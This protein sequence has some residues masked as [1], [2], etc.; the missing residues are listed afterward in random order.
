M[1]KHILLV[2]CF[3]TISCALI[4]Q[5]P[6]KITMLDK[7][8]DE[9]D[10]RICG[11]FGNR[12]DGICFI[13]SDK[14][15]QSFYVK[16]LGADNKFKT[17]QT[18]PSELKDVWLNAFEL[19]G[20]NSNLIDLLDKQGFSDQGFFR[21]GNKYYLLTI[22][23]K[24]LVFMV[25]EVD[26][27]QGK[28]KFPGKNIGSIEKEFRWTPKEVIISPN[29]EKMWVFQNNPESKK[30]V[31]KVVISCSAGFNQVKRAVVDFGYEQKQ[32]KFMGG[33]A[34]D[35]NLYCLY[36]L[37][38][39][40]QV[41][42]AKLNGVKPEVVATFSTDQ[43]QFTSADVKS[44]GVGKF[45]IGGYYSQVKK[46]V[47]GWFTVQV[48]NGV[49]SDTYYYTF[50]KELVSRYDEE[51][52][53]KS[54][55]LLVKDLLHDAS[56]GQVT[57]IGQ[58]EV[59]QATDGFAF[60]FPNIF[61]K[62][63]N[64]YAAGDAYYT[65]YRSI[66]VS[67]SNVAGGVTFSNKIPV[68]RFSNVVFMRIFSHF[69]VK[70]KNYFLFNEKDS[71]KNSLAEINKSPDQLRTIEG[72]VGVMVEADEKGNLKKYESGL[73][74]GKAELFRGKW[75]NIDQNEFLGYTKN[76]DIAL[77]KFE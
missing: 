22:S 55:A 61:S 46:E 65:T 33:T 13:A 19:G 4:G 10:D 16:K 20:G 43:I 77:I 57:V 54:H 6:F 47:S 63:Q 64:W 26:L 2:C 27:K 31:S 11:M 73:T 1:R 52:N 29:H 76:G 8:T 36:E 59:G 9:K 50:P 18:L 25:Y 71:N 5:N 49:K 21:L 15:K 34:D 72:G 60:A 44:I 30:T 38:D 51:K 74:N 14:K 32:V 70:G 62:Y 45:V 48:N 53:F 40:N 7:V 39:K 28:I 75:A 24:D 42:F 58:L 37:P 23:K 3:I 35:E 67:Q 66:Y 56:T 68:H 17:T 12:A 69:N 41:E